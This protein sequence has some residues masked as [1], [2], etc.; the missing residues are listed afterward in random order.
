MSHTVNVFV[1]QHD[2]KVPVV[3]R[4]DFKYLGCKVKYLKL[5]AQSGF[6]DF[7]YFGI[8]NTWTLSYLNDLVHKQCFHVKMDRPMYCPNTNTLC[9]SPELRVF[10]SNHLFT[11]QLWHPQKMHKKS[12]WSA[13]ELWIRFDALWN[14]GGNQ[15]YR[16]LKI[17]S[18][19][20][21]TWKPSII[22]HIH[23]LTG[24]G[25]VS[26]FLSEITSTSGNFAVDAVLRH[27][28]FQALLTGKACSLPPMKSGKTGNTHRGQNARV[29]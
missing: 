22:V 17:A 16:F 18:K 10:F 4:L 8:F 5:W 1:T 7:T 27:L 6:W 26:G 28:G 9:R 23:I 24:D 13:L 19:F 25:T 20:W 15:H 14:K 29:S 2:R 12:I 11:N 21:P 3:G